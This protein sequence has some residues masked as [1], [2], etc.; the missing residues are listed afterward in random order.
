MSD[1]MFRPGERASF[2]VS[3]IAGNSGAIAIRNS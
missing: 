1:L 2:T 3:D